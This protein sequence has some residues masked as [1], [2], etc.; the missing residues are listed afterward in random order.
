MTKIYDFNDCKT[1][2]LTYGGNAGQ[3]LGI[4][5]ENENYM[6]KFPK[7][8]TG[9]RNMKISY[10]TSPLSEFLGSQIYE[11]MSI[12]VH[13]TKLG[14][15]KNKLVVIC[16][17]IEF[18]K[19]KPIGR[20]SV[21]TQLKNVFN[22]TTFDSYSNTD[23]THL[24]SILAEIQSN[25]M[26]AP[27]K[28]KVIERFWTMFIIDTLV[29][30]NDRNNGNWGLLVNGD[31][32]LA[33]VFDNGNSFNNKFSD[34]EMESRLNRMSEVQCKMV[35]SVFLDE[36]SKKIIPYD[37]FQTHNILELNHALQ[38]IM[39]M[40]DLLKISKIIDDLPLEANGIKV[41]S[42]VAKTFMKKGLE[43][44]YNLILQPALAKIQDIS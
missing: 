20:L 3:K 31:V 24:F 42:D 2:N 12:P 10:T 32:K 41:T 25:P 30:N 34:G 13:E 33:P 21:F 37:F 39:P 16:K 4:V 8:T 27:I 40:I 36:N 17:D 11:S 22:E 14:I 35:N 44:R 7:N 29:Y 26:I 38:K 5:F 6:L 19:T 23:D 1:T 15:C 28:E 9:M 18:D 43:E